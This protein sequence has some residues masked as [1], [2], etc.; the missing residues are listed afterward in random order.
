MRKNA[1]VTYILE[2][3][4]YFEPNYYF[5]LIVINSTA[6]KNIKKKKTNQI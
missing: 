5:N 6:E 1:K 3:M 4:E 2:Q